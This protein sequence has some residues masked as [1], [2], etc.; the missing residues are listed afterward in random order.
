MTDPYAYVR[1]EITNGMMLK[2]ISVPLRTDVGNSFNYPFILNNT[3]TNILHDWYKIHELPLS[4][5][6][7]AYDG[8]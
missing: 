1:S 4:L 8:R 5:I 7:I 3:F 6:A 2:L